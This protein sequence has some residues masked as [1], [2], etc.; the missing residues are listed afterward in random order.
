MLGFTNEE[1]QAAPFLDFVHP[2]DRA[3]S[4]DALTRATGGA[5]I[6][7]FENRYRTRDGSY[8]WLEWTAA[9]AQDRGVVYAAARD[10]TERKQADEALRQ[11]AEDLKHLV[12][13]LEKER[14]KAESASAAKG[15]FLANMS[16]EI[17]TPMNAIIG[18]TG[19]AL[20]TRL[21]PDQREYMRTANESAEALLGIIN[22][23]LDFSKIEAG[24]LALEAIPFS[25]REAVE[26]RG[27]GC[28]PLRAHEKGLELAC[29][30]K[31]RRAR[32]PD[33]RSGPPA[34]GADQSRGQRGQVHRSRRCRRRGVRRPRDDRR[35]GAALHDLGHRHRHPA[36][37][38]VADF[39][40]VRA[41][42]HVDD[43]PVRGHR[44]GPDDLRAAGRDDGRPD[45]ADE[46]AR[47][48][49][50]VSIRG[51][52]RVQQQPV[53]APTPAVDR[54]ACRC[55]SWT[56]TRRI[57][58]SCRS[59]WSAGACTRKWPTAPRRPSRR[60]GTE[61]RGNARSISFWPMR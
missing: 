52:V 28:S 60:C 9:P 53:A 34:A 11:S 40:R 41:G 12:G 2:D 17:R 39:R 46:R 49:Q 1:L 57:A 8:R 31:R 7:N 4:L 18:M 42:R 25:L 36:R 33:R 38:A 5:L 21:D 13:E 55:S 19:L 23:V 3:A 45:L 32:Q 58:R 6:I 43:A 22:D 14:K 24:K 15:E 54:M 35:S 50:P 59:C 27:A 56:T 51:A 37:Q 61:R 30:I 29:R 20:R 16:H 10:I 44:A 26:G 47:A 48:G